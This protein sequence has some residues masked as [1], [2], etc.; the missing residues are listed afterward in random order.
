MNGRWGGKRK[1]ETKSSMVNWKRHPHRNVQHIVTEI[2][3][4]LKRN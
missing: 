4:I 2:L 1:R 3:L